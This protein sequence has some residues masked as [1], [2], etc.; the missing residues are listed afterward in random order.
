[1]KLSAAAAALRQSAEESVAVVVPPGL[2]MY[3][4]IDSIKWCM[5]I[6]FDLNELRE[7][8]ISERK[9]IDNVKQREQIERE[10]KE[11]T[12]NI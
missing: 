12:G 5:Y 2:L 4:K 1:M 7:N 9:L 3:Q 11:K 6:E 10:Q 8:C